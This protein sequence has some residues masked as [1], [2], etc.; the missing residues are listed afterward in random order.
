MQVGPTQRG[1]VAQPSPGGPRLRAHGKRRSRGP[2]V[3]HPPARPETHP[4]LFSPAFIPTLPSPTP[5][6]AFSLSRAARIPPPTE[7][8]PRAPPSPSGRNPRR[9]TLVRRRQARRAAVGP[10]CQIRTL[11]P[12]CS[13]GGGGGALGDFGGAESLIGAPRDSRNELSA[14]G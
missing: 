3:H 4:I 7:P 11:L 8:A 1:H 2:R 9:G 6:L 13:R 14:C 5:P 10:N 12:A